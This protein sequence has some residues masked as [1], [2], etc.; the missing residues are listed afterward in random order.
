MLFGSAAVISLFGLLAV[1]GLVFVAFIYDRRVA[2]TDSH[3]ILPKPTQ[4]GLSCDEI[5]IPLESISQVC[6]H[7]FIGASKLLRIDHSN[8]VVSIPSIMFCSIS[9]FY[10]MCRAVEGAADSR[11]T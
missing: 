3:V 1:G 5:Q 2:L 10:A 11:S 9:E 8:G 7:D 6:V 4:L